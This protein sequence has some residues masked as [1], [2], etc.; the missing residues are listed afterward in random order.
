M[1]FHYCISDCDEC[2]RL[3]PTFIKGY[4][5]KGAACILLKQFGR[6][7]SAYEKALEIDSNNQVRLILHIFNRF[8]SKITGLGSV[9]RSKASDGR[10]PIEKSRRN[11]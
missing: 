4:I 2:I 1:E 5:R 9:R 3:D 7:K 8:T 10:R 6:A 11:S